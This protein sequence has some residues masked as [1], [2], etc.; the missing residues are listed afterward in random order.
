[1]RSEEVIMT[2]LRGD[3]DAFCPARLSGFGINT[4][5]GLIVTPS[6]RWAIS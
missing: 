3:F 6:T 4:I 2:V 1:M 5:D